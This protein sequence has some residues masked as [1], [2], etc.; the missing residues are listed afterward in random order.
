MTDLD[1]LQAFR[2]LIGTIG[3]DIDDSDYVALLRDIAREATERAD[4]VESNA[5]CRRYPPGSRIRFTVDVDTGFAIIPA[6]A[7]ATVDSCDAQHVH[8]T[9]DVPVGKVD[10][11]EWD[12]VA[13][14]EKDAETLKP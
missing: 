12:S 7:L 13:D 4:S 2:T 3:R 8:A 14:L 1:I 11:C 10:F 6:G 9:L 5:D